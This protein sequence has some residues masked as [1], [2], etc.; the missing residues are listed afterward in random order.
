MPHCWKDEREHIEDVSGRPWWEHDPD[1][2]GA[3]CM[4]EDGHDGAHVF[5]D[6]SEI[7]LAFVPSEDHS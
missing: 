7:R 6:D 2:Q 3:T 5:T 1:M 4:L